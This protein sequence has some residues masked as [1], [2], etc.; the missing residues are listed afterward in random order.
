[1]LQLVVPINCNAV[2]LRAKSFIVV[3]PG[4]RLSSLPSPSARPPTNYNKSRWPLEEPGGHFGHK[5]EWQP[6]CL[7]P[8]GLA[9]FEKKPD[10][11]QQTE[12]AS[13]SN[14]N[15]VFLTILDSSD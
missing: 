5:E 3:S 1:M 9:G 11:S 10:F 7:R 6:F 12:T 13:R 4:C 14:T 2:A 15:C 8:R